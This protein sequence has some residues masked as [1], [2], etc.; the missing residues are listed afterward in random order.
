M[1][2]FDQ[3]KAGLSIYDSDSFKNLFWPSY[4]G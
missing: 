2:W 1:D 3:D 4:P